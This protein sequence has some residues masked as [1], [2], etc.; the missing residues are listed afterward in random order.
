MVV[1]AR[2]LSRNGYITWFESPQ[3]RSVYHVYGSLL[4]KTKGREMTVGFCWEQDMR[5]RCLTG[6]Q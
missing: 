2:D 5:F 3:I 1:W 6:G 4:Q